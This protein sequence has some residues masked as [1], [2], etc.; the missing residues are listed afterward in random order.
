MDTLQTLE[1]AAA[2]A[3][4]PAVHYGGDEFLLVPAATDLAAGRGVLE[5]LKRNC[6]AHPWQADAPALR[7][8]LSVGV[9]LH[10][11]GARLE[12]TIASAD[13]ALY[14]A[15]RAGR[16]RVALAP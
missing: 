4:N 9:A 6:D 13:A 14:E 8:S 3:G 5:R 7:V 16:N 10:R 15:K 2:Q 1:Q 12:A 11:H